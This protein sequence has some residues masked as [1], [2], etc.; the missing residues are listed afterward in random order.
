MKIEYEAKFL[1]PD[2]EVF[3][4]M[5]KEK[6]AECVQPER[7]MRRWIA[8]SEYE[9]GK[10][11]RLRDEGNKVTLT[12]KDRSV[13]SVDGTKEVE[14]TVSNFD[15]TLKILKLVGIKK[16]GYQENKRESWQLNGVEVEIDTWPGVEPF[17]EIEGK[18]ELEVKR[19]AE[20]LG[21]DWNNARHD[22][23]DELYAEQNGVTPKEAFKIFDD[24][25]FPE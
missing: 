22:T 16:K 19:T 4:A 25:R 21:F 14:V 5:L 6:G 2:V 8:G 11:L 12:F 15:D 17:V 24:L 18:T 1:V 23:A 20:A 9:H 10:W 7:L 13:R 3:R